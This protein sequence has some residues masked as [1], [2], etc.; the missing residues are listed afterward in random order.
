M[1]GTFVSIGN[2]PRHFVR[3]LDEVARIA[4]SLPQP[5][6]VQRGRTPFDHPAIKHFSFV[7]AETFQ[8]LLRGS[9]LFITHAGGGSVLAAL[10]MGKTPVVVPRLARFGEHVDDHQ[11]A[12]A[13]ELAKQGKIVRVDDIAQLRAAAETALACPPGEIL[14]TNNDAA[15]NAVASAVA[16]F[17]PERDDCV[18]LITPS[19]GHLAEIRE[20]SSAYCAHPHFFVVNVPL[21]EPEDMRGRT[22]VITLSE[23]D[24]KFLINLWEAVAILREWRPKVLLTTG[25]GFSVAF[26]VVGKLLG[27]PTIYIETVG[28]VT[29]PTVTGRF[30]YRLADRFF[31]QWPNLARYFPRGEYIGLVL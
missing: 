28:K 2:S 13:E 7:D 3:L 21:V 6:V 12:L 14:E 24:W 23:R 5:I 27:I 29:V 18:A 20:L 22:V 1:A 16:Q 26:T 25:G 19:G 8:D 11:I 4:S 10:R 31:Y 17:A 15:V 30:M 9:Q